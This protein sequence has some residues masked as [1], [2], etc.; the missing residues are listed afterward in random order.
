MSCSL[1]KSV[2]SKKTTCPD[3]PLAQVK[4]YLNHPLAMKQEKYLIYL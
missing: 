4:D 3:N 2:G 1:C